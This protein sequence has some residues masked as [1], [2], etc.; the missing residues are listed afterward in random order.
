MPVESSIYW[1]SIDSQRT[2]SGGSSNNSDRHYVDPW[3]LENYAYLRRHSISV[4]T[5]RHRHERQTCY[6]AEYWYSQSVREP[7]YSVPAFVEKLYCNSPCRK[8]NNAYYYHHPIYE[9]RVPNCVAPYPIYAP[10]V[11]AHVPWE[12]MENESIS[13]YDYRASLR[14]DL[15]QSRYARNYFHSSVPYDYIRQSE[16][17]RYNVPEEYYTSTPPIEENYMTD[18][19][20]LNLDLNTYGHLKIDYTDSWNSLKRKIN[21]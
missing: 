21:K 11:P 5:L 12:I 3:D 1:N 13:E 18:I 6:Q 14:S 7:Q 20:P 8:E 4:P 16:T 15:L 19:T 9:D 10:V 17:L 2:T